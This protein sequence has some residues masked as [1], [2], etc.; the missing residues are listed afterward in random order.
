MIKNKGETA[1]LLPS[2][3][4][5]ETQTG[6][7]WDRR[8]PEN[9]VQSRSSSFFKGFLFWAAHMEHSFITGYRYSKAFLS[10]MLGLY[11]GVEKQALVYSAS[12]ELSMRIEREG[13]AP[14]RSH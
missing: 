7:P 13:E 3:L 5:T 2:S 1:W 12:L 9:S 6:S 14:M 4:P 11:L 10:G 8:Q